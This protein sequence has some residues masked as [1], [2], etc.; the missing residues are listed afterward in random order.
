MLYMNKIRSFFLCLLV[1][2]AACNS[3]P[4]TVWSVT[5]LAPVFPDYT[6]ITIP[7]NIA[8]L[9]FMIEGADGI[10]VVVRGQNDSI[11]VRGKDKVRF[12]IDEWKHLLRKERGHELRVSVLACKEG[13][14]LT[15][16]AF[17]WKIAAEPVDRY[18]SYRLIEPG[19]EVWN[20]LQLCERCV[21]NFEEKVIADN[22]LTGGNCMNCHIYG[23]QNGSLS[24][25][26]LRGKGGG[27][28]L[29]RDNKL[30]KLALQADSMISAAVYGDFHPSGR[31]AVFSS[32]L[33][34]PAFHALGSRRLEVFDT[35]SDLLIADF[36]R[37]QLILS[38][39]TADK[40]ALETFP[41]FSA[42]GRWVYFCTAPNVVL[43]D[44]ICLLKYSLC[45][46]RFEA[47]TGKWGTKVDTLWNAQVRKGSVCFPKVSPDGKFMLFTL[48]DYGTFPIW[49]RETD[50]YLMN[51]IEG[52]VQACTEAN[53]NRSDTYHS[54]SS[55]SRWFVFA[56]K[57]GDGQYGKPYLAYMDS[58]GNVRKPFALPQHD[59]EHYLTTFKSYNIPEL[60]TTA[61]PFD[62][63]DIKRVYEQVPAERFTLVL[64]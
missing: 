53:S 42:D 24:L 48:A 25:F 40:E 6:D 31:Y 61:L 8:P 16:P 18:L 38:P 54:W 51:L 56:S 13:R 28:V 45:R 46:I 59:P 21:E 33:I 43:P 58:L 5:D 55:N 20:N 37:N 19:Y 26:H 63:M 22:K 17:S 34:I 44:S 60:S 27:T 29:N 49:H 15:Y 10:W 32:N 30:R 36:D 57:R 50:L 2:L 11:R 1:G 12:P 23:R 3:V 39:L 4:D 64:Q 14:W 35:E 62:A 7:Y 47:E 9:N 52:T 41:A